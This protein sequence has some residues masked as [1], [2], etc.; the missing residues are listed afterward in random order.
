MV[1]RTIRAAALTVTSDPKAASMSIPRPFPRNA[2]TP[3]LTAAR[4]L[5]RSRGGLTLVEVS[6]STLIVGMLMVASLQS[7]ANVGRT[8]TAT[9]QLVDGQGLAQE[10]IRE[11]LAQGYTD[12]TDPNATTWGPEGSESNRATFNDLDDYSGWTESPV[13]N[14]AGTALTGYTGWTRSV[15]V[16]LLNKNDYSVLSAGSV[17]QGLRAVTVTVT[18]PAGKTTIAKVYR[19]KVG[20]TQQPLSADAT[21]VT[22]VGCTLKL[23]TN[24]PATTGVSLSNHAEDQ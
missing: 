6:I 10:L 19:S 20:G 24:T 8:W 14:A 17:D 1:P 22:W 12:P 3:P 18:S 16:Q 15:V 9:N 21:F 13:K 2:A 5:L 23:G 7:V 11:I 4:S